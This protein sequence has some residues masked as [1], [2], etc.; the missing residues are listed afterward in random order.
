LWLRKGTTGRAKN[1][2]TWKKMYHYFEFTNEEF[3][4]QYRQRSNAETPFHMIKSKF[5]DSVRARR[6]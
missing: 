2:P 4:E 6:K 3:L 1:T 5:E